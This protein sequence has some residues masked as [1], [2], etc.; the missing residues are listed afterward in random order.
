MENTL[1]G[2]WSDLLNLSDHFKTAWGSLNT[3]SERK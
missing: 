1:A 3:Y 2:D